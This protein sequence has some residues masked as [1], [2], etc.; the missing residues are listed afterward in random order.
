MSREDLIPFNKRTEEEQ[1]ELAKKG[2]QASGA[3]RR[4]KKHLKECMQ[5]ILDMPVND[6]KS[7]NKMR[8]LGIDEAD[9]DNR[10]RM[11]MTL[12]V[13]AISGDVAAIKQVRS[14]VD[15]D[16]DKKKIDIEKKKL[17][18]QSRLVDIQEQRAKITG[19]W[20]DIDPA[21]DEVFGDE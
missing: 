1:K 17:I 20:E 16:N 15:E 8:A 6:V 12:Y 19:E 10:M 4:R 13:Q 14:I 7:Q 11:M 18:L 21:R 5:A 3:A 2:G 9:M